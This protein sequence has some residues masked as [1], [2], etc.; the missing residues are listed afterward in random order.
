MASQL[1]TTVIVTYSKSGLSFSES[2]VS[3]TEDLTGGGV[4]GGVVSVTTAAMA[5]PLGGVTTPGGVAVFKNL[6]AMNYIEIGFDSSGFVSF[7]KLLPGQVACIPLVN[8]PWARANTA[9]CLM[10]FKIMDR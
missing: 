2:T 5:I 9:A 4:G 10:Q 1:T 7:A 6:N 3:T 8:A